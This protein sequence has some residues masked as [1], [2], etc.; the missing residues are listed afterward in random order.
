[1]PLSALCL[2]LPTFS[3]D[4][5]LSGFFSRGFETFNLFL[6][7]KQSGSAPRV[8]SFFMTIPQAGLRQTQAFVPLWRALRRHFAGKCLKNVYNLSLKW[9]VKKKKKKVILI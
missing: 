1:M 5:H 4:F 7:P 6:S 2:S 3:P 8:I 9:M